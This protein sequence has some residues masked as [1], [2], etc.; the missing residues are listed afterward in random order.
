MSGRPIDI[1]HWS[2]IASE[3]TAWARAGAPVI[4]AC[5]AGSVYIAKRPSAGAGR[6]TDWEMTVRMENSPRPQKRETPISVGRPGASRLMALCE[7]IV[8]ERGC[9]RMRAIEAG[10]LSNSLSHMSVH[11]GPRG[12]TQTLQVAWS[13][14]NQTT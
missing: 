12:S 1:E 14:P 11:A 9:L 13:W 3:W 7:Y 10:L 4:A 2:R 5:F 8:A 6:T